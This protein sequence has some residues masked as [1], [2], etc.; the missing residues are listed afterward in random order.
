M[1]KGT[2]AAALLAVAALTSSTVYAAVDT[3]DVV[4]VVNQHNALVTQYQDAQPNISP[5][6]AEAQA[7]A[8]ITA[9]VQQ[10]IQ[11]ATTDE[12][13]QSILQAA[14]GAAAPYGDAVVAAV[15]SGA[16]AAGMPADVITTVA[17]LLPDVNMSAVT[18]ATAAGGT[19]APGTG[20]PASIAGS[21]TSPGGVGF[22]G[23]SGGGGGGVASNN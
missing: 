7:N 2:I 3:S 16:A 22:G 10:L 9:Q 5:E 6:T 15:A 19:P 13:K 4:A 18:Q 8:E 12:D 1:S 14:L 11:A 23:G 17:L 21:P 20:T